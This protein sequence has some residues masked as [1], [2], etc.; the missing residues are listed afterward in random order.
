MTAPQLKQQ[1]RQWLASVSVKDLPPP[2]TSLLVFTNESLDEAF[3]KLLSNRILSAP[4]A[5]KT[6]VGYVGFLDIRALVSAIVSMDHAKTTSQRALELGDL[7]ARLSVG[8][9]TGHMNGLFIFL[10]TFSHYYIIF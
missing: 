3:G 9:D 10:A 4:V 7:V 8:D 6:G 1:V 5:T 2:S